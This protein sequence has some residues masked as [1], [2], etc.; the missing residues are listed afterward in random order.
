MKDAR[1][2]AEALADNVAIVRWEDIPTVSRQFVGKFLFETY[3][4]AEE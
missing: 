4:E 2:L 1:E 3:E